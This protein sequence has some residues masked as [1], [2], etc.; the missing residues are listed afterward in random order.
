MIDLRSRTLA[1]LTFSLLLLPMTVACADDITLIETGSTLL[2]PLF[3]VLASEYAKT[4]PGVHITAGSTGSDAGIEQEISGAAHIGA[5]DAYMTDTQA[6]R[7][8]QIINV[9]MAIS[10]QTTMTRRD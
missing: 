6:K 3:S 7:N 5:S 10:A 4:H 8:L 1:A 2:Y 9:P